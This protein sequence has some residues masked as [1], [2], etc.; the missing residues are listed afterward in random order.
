MGAMTPWKVISRIS[1]TG[2]PFND[3]PS[4]EMWLYFD[5]CLIFIH[6]AGRKAI[7]SQPNVAYIADVTTFFR[8]ESGAAQKKPNRAIDKLA[9]NILF[10]GQSAAAR[11]HHRP[12]VWRKRECAIV[13]RNRGSACRT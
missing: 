12:G 6:D 11:D 13:G 3:I 9:I 2:V 1:L 7:S 8:N 4:R 10:S 5:T